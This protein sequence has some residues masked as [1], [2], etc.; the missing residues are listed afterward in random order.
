MTAEEMFKKLGYINIYRDEAY[1]KY[2]DKKSFTSVLITF[3][4]IRQTFKIELLDENG[5]YIYD[6]SI[7]LLRAINKQVEELGW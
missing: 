2:E 6:I 7:E 5:V 1:I 3:Y 4:P